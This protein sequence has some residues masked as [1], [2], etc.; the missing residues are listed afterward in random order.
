M[1]LNIKKLALWL[2]I[3]MLISLSLSGVLF[4]SAGVSWADFFSFTN[5]RMDEIKYKTDINE[6][7]IISLDN[8]DKFE[9]NTISSNINFII[10]NRED[11]KVNFKGFVSSSNSQEWPKLVIDNLGEKVLVNVKYPKG[12]Q[13]GLKVSDLDLDIYIPENYSKDLYVHT[14]SG[15]V[16]L[17]ILKPNSFEFKSISG[18]LVANGIL[19]NE[20]NIA[21]TSGDVKID[22][23]SGDLNFKSVSGDLIVNYKDSLDNNIK[24]DTTSGDIDIRLPKDA[25]FFLDTKTVSGDINCDFPLTL[26]GSINNKNLKGR[27]GDGKNKIDI[28]TISGEINITE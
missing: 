5:I 8:L 12:I 3:I 9:V 17:D 18:N 4:S 25:S 27:R 26:E 22:S 2:T 11:I 7:R 13:L 16:K 19:A 23:F 1:G 14:T 20:G 15:D 24:L 6:E 28:S 10:E 21:T